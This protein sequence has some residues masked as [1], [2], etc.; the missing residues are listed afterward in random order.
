MTP[1]NKKS[2]FSSR[3]LTL[4]LFTL[5]ALV[6]YLIF[7][8]YPIIIG[9]YYSLTDWNGITK[10]F[11]FVGLKNY[12]N[13]VMDDRFRKSFFFTFRYAI[14]L[15]ILTIVI[16]M[17]LALLLNSKI[18]GKSFFRGIY[19]FPAVISML[20]AG[21]IFNEIFY[22]VLPVIG[23]TLHIS[24]LQ[25]SILSNPDLAM[26]GI[27]FV[28]LWQG[29]AIPTV[30]LMAGL[31][32]IPSELIESASLEGANK[33]HIFKYI[34]IPFVLPIITVVVVLVF[35]DGLMLFDY[36][37]GLTQG[38][39]AGSTESVALLIYNHGFK[40]VKFSYGIA[41]S[42]VLCVI[43]CAISFIQIGI[44]NKKKVY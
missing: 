36:V 11:N 30:L 23:E 35:K 20:T 34:T 21:L 32:S 5:P 24:F 1:A 6:L 2:K 41:E 26:Y 9:G 27:M 16:S 44:N 43:V 13:I 28:H 4:F 31:Q 25:T 7:F 12:F 22:R 33:W 38:G 15:L 37:V 14:I 17:F 19:F 42:V 39:P 3:E 18:K 8:I 29:V 10:K 40:E